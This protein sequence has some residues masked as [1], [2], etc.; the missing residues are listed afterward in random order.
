MHTLLYTNNDI[1]YKSYRESLRIFFFQE[2]NV[3]MDR[4]AKDVL[5]LDLMNTAM[6]SLIHCRLAT[7]YTAQQQQKGIY[8]VLCERMHCWKE[9]KSW[10]G[11]GGSWG[12]SHKGNTE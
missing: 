1:I 8:T 4:N 3:A 9:C 7:I 6:N 5:W 10:V 2:A 12:L 11:K